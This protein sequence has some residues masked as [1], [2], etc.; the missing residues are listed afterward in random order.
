MTWTVRGYVGLE[1]VN[2]EVGSRVTADSIRDDGVNRLFGR[3]YRGNIRNKRL[4]IL[5][6]T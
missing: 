6:A 3:R 2:A 4:T 5:H 1:M